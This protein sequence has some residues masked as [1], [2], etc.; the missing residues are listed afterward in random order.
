[1]NLEPF[2]K[3]AGV[4]FYDSELVSENGKK[5]YRIY[6]YKEGGVNLD[7]CARLSE[8]L[9]PIFDIEPPVDTEY[10]LE[11]SSPGLERKLQ[12]LEHFAKSIGEKVRITTN[13]KEQIEAKILGLK[14]TLIFLENEKGEKISL[15]FGN[16]KKAKTFVEW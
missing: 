1:M 12:T 13:E 4:S 5:I 9:S 14:D 15:E 7:D 8:I 11:V 2:C 16:I 10:F 6:I 3:E